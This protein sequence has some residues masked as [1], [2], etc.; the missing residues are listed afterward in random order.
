RIVTSTFARSFATPEA[1]RKP[2]TEYP[3]VVAVSLVPTCIH[4]VEIVDVLHLDRAGHLLQGRMRIEV[5]TLDP[6]ERRNHV[7]HVDEDTATHCPGGW[8]RRRLGATASRRRL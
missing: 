1:T 2:V 8:S 4:E 3:F 6:E 5:P 7:P